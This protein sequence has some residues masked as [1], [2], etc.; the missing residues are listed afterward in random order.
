[1]RHPAVLSDSLSPPIALNR[2]VSPSQRLA[3]IAS[4][5]DEFDHSDADL[6]DLEIDMGAARALRL[7]L[8]YVLRRGRKRQ[9]VDQL[10]TVGDICGA[11]RFVVVSCSDAKR[12]ECY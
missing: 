9:R 1:V 3:A 8:G 10:E 6:H 7:Q 2:A 12:L 4:A 5:Q 11:L